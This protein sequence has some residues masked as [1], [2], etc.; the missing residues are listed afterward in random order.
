MDE[1]KPRANDN[2]MLNSIARTVGTT[3]G[4]IV[5]KATQFTDEAAAQVARASKPATALVRKAKPAMRKAKTATRKAKV[6]KKRPAAK[7]RK[8]VVAKRTGRKKARR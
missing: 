3:A 4:I 1:K 2:S 7:K 6:T 8:K 5:S